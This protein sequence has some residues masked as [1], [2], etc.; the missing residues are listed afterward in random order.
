MIDRPRGQRRQLS[1][2][3]YSPHGRAGARVMTQSERWASH[4]LSSMSEV[5]ARTN[6]REQDEDTR[7]ARNR[8]RRRFNPGLVE[9]WPTPIPR[10]SPCAASSRHCDG[11]SAQASQTLRR[12]R[13][14]SLS[15][16]RSHDRLGMDQHRA[17][18]ASPPSSYCRKQNFHATARSAWAGGAL[19]CRCSALAGSQIGVAAAPALRLDPHHGCSS[20]WF[21][22]PA[23]LAREGSSR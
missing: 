10:F 14:R 1:E 18:A 19:L 22:I 11:A 20:S 3:S 15:F 21:P 2:S 16:P 23:D 8:N 4:F 12:R 6:R 5:Y 9:T 13:W 7:F 17:S